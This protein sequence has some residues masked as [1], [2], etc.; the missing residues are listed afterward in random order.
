MLQAAKGVSRVR[1]TYETDD[2]DDGSRVLYYYY[3]IC[4][5]YLY[6]QQWWR[7]WPAVDGRALTLVMCCVPFCDRPSAKV[8]GP[9]SGTRDSER[10][11]NVRCPHESLVQQT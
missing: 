4:N 10:T 2:D 6:E 11:E 7:C 8:R 3:Y 1:C 9:C 5:I